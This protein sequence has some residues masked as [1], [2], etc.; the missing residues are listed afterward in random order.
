MKTRAQLAEEPRT[1]QFLVDAICPHS[2]FVTINRDACLA[3]LPLVVWVDLDR[4]VHILPDDP[5]KEKAY[6]VRRTEAEKHRSKVG[7]TTNGDFRVC[8]HMGRLIE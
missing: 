5:C 4:P 7:A 6:R 1:A 8:S 3:Q 2:I